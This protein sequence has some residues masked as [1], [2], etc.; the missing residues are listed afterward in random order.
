MISLL[1]YLKAT[2]S[3]IKNL[4]SKPDTVLYPA[5]SVAL[6]ADYRGA[7]VLAEPEKCL[8][9][10]K[11]MRICPTHAI[12]I[13]DIDDETAKFEIN[14]GRCCYCGEC[15]DGCTFSAIT[16]TQNINTATLDKTELIKTVIV[17]KRSKRKNKK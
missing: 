5:D 7:P 15:Q 3:T 10:L 4:I 2:K 16:L 14:L 1:D 11:C 12:N 13:S 9:C 8:L 17:P 6:P